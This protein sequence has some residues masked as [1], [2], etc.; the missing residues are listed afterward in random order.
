MIESKNKILGIA[1]GLLILALIIMWFAGD[2]F[3]DNNLDDSFE[4]VEIRDDDKVNYS[5]ESVEMQVES[6]KIQ[7]DDKINYSFEDIGT[8]REVICGD[9]ICDLPEIAN[10][11]CP[12]DCGE[13]VSEVSEV[14]EAPEVNNKEVTCGDGICDLFEMANNSCP[15]D[16]GV[17]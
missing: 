12:Q 11:D 14:I 8:R 13:E 3:T 9:G 1:L 15:Q 7:S 2:K 6:A 4:S 10:K 5:F 17:E 16:C